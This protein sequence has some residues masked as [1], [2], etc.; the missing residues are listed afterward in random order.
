LEAWDPPESFAITQALTFCVE[1]IPA[2]HNKGTALRA[3]LTHLN[4]LP[5]TEPIDP[6]NVIT[7][8]D[9]ENDISMFQVAGISVAM[10]NAMPAAKAAAR[11]V[12]ASNDEG[13]LGRFLETI[14]FSK[15]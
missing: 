11:Y 3:L 1:L 10:G 12:T 6:A 14:F 15:S 9:G 2:K 7:F 13:G 8:G 5:G 4:S